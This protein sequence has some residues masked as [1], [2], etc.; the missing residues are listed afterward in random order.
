MGSVIGLVAAAAAAGEGGG[1]LWKSSTWMPFSLFSTCFLA[2]FRS[3][4]ACRYCRMRSAIR[5][6]ALA[7]ASSTSLLVLWPASPNRTWDTCFGELMLNSFPPFSAYTLLWIDSLLDVRMSTCVIWPLPLDEP[8]ISC[9]TSTDRFGA[10]AFAKGEAADGVVSIMSAY[11]SKDGA[12]VSGCS[13]AS[14]STA[15]SALTSAVFS[16]GAFGSS[17]VETVEPTLLSLL[18]IMLPISSPLSPNCGSDG[19]K[20]KSKPVV[21]SSSPSNDPTNPETPISSS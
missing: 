3:R 13:A 20:F 9:T 14:M 18:L 11:R 5:F 12:L 1:V 10:A 15:V 2:R 17:D 21:G 16:A 7:M 6:P 4:C 19:S 8:A